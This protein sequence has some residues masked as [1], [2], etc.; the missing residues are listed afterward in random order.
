MAPVQ[1]TEPTYA[2]TGAWAN[3]GQAILVWRSGR[4]VVT[5]FY[6]AIPGQESFEPLIALSRAV[7]LRLRSN[8]LP[9]FE[10]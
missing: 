8:P 1:I 5:A 3:A 6:T 4:V 10:P 9:P 2:Y 7:E